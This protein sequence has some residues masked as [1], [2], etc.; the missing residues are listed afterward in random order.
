[1]TIE[2]AETNLSATDVLEDELWSISE[3]K[4]YKVKLAN[5]YEQT[6]II[7]FAKWISKKEQ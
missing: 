6:E 2:A 1:M 7:D 5:N 4:D 3:F